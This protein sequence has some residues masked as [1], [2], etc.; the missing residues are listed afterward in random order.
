MS[1]RIYISPSNQVNNVYAHGNTNEMEQ[2]NKIAQA[3]ET[4]LKRCGFL[5]LHEYPPF[6]CKPSRHQ[7]SRFAS[8]FVGKIR[9]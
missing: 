3:C 6:G 2:C 8:A 9:A 4:A 5:Q 7:V 1:K